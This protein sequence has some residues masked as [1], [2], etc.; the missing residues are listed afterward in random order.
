[1]ESEKK[2]YLR[3]WIYGVYAENQRA[4]YLPQDLCKTTVYGVYI[5]LNYNHKCHYYHQYV[6]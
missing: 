6:S 4:Q 2:G 3:K 5:Y 1:M